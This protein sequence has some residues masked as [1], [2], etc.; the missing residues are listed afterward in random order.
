M[1]DL[2]LRERERSGN[3]IRIGM[4]GSGHAARMVALHLVSGIPGMRLCAIA[5]RRP[6]Q[7]VRAFAEAGVSAV[8]AV[9]AAAELDAV[10]SRG[11]CAV[12]GD[13]RA[14]CGSETLDIVVEITG[15]IDFAAQATLDLIAAK[16][17]VVLVNAELDAT[18]GPVL[19]SYADRAGVVLTNTDGDEPGV[20]MTLVRYLRSIGLKPVAGGNLK[21]LIDHK[22]N[23]ETQKAFAQQYGQDAYKVASFAD[24]TK[25][26][27]ETTVLANAAGFGAG[28]RGMHGP[29]AKHVREMAS[30]LPAEEMLAGGIV[31]YALGAEPYTGAFVV[32]HEPDAR[33]VAHLKFLKMGDG[34]FFVFY[35]PYHLPH[36]QI[37]S[38]IGRAVLQHDATVAPAGQASCDVIAMAKRP[39]KAGGVIDGLGGFDS[40]GLVDTHARARA[41]RCLPLGLAAGCT[42]VRPVAEDAPILWDDVVVP[43]GRLIDRLWN[44]QHMLF[45]S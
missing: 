38:T 11:G 8:H 12:T 18:L 22:R 45:T 10:V 37:A 43:P 2:L 26:A 31:D 5:A 1:I 13:Y 39:L 36:V 35:T 19:K 3:P 15:T 29:A 41:D 34:P 42:L 27:M 25:L 16:K 40:Y 30:L 28:I 21:G 23:P 33:K 9:A 44:E 24:G 14:L 6:D 17:H 20:A 32:V 7:G 4:I